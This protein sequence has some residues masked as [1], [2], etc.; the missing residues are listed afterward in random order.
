M[1]ITIVVVFQKFD[2]RTR[3]HVQVSHRLLARTDVP[4]TAF[5][6]LDALPLSRSLVERRMTFL[7]VVFA[8]S[9]VVV[10][11]VHYAASKWLLKKS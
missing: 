3:R 8:K 2:T 9:L 5:R 6:P 4:V 10:V 7:N 11:L 1:E